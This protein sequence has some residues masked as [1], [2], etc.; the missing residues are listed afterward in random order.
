MKRETI[1]IGRKLILNKINFNFKI[2]IQKERDRKNLKFKDNISYLSRDMIVFAL[3][4][5]QQTMKRT[6]YIFISELTN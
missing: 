5:I 3:N 2:L 6:I 4:H 1:K